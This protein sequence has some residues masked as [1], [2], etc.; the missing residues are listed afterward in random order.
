MENADTVQAV[1]G[2]VKE[3]ALK[4]QLV[5]D[6]NGTRY[7]YTFRACTA[8][9]SAMQK[10]FANLTGS[11]HM[12]CPSCAANFSDFST[13]WSYAEM[14]KAWQKTIPNVA[15][16]LEEG[17]E[18][19]TAVGIKSGAPMILSPKE[20]EL[21]PRLLKWAE[22][23]IKGLDNLHNAKGVLHTVLERLKK[24]TQLF[25]GKI[26]ERL[27]EDSLQRRASSELDGSHWREAAVR[28]EEV[29]MPAFISKDEHMLAG[30]RKFFHYWN[31]VYYYLCFFFAVQHTND[32]FLHHRC[33]GFSML[34]QK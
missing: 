15:K 11:A 16:K 19:H 14:A 26:F 9:N 31:E 6:W 4:E 20:M 3:E 7:C 18:A 23:F 17:E 1:V 27:I 5:L 32:L 13:I 22:D 12:R 24:E 10:I 29:I 34:L 8:D 25:S 28:Y 2:A 21:D 30:F 33:S